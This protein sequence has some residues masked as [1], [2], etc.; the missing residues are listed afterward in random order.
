MCVCESAADACSKL[1]ATLL[2][3]QQRQPGLSKGGGR[4]HEVCINPGEREH[5]IRVNCVVS[6]FTLYANV[7]RRIESVFFFDEHSTNSQF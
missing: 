2:R 1:R 5:A 4:S 7:F 6:S 3:A